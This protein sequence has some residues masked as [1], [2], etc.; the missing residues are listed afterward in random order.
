MYGGFST[1]SKSKA[2]LCLGS[3]TFGIIDICKDSI[4]GLEP[5]CF[6]SDDDSALRVN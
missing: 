5:K 3:Q 2:E 6:C 1:K 4:E